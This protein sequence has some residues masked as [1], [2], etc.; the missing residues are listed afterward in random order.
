M[1]SSQ[2]LCVAEVSTQNHQEQA[3]D[4][5]AKWLVHFSEPE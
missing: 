5:C 3:K 2:A 1:G 4:D